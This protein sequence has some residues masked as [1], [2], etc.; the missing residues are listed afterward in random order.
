MLIIVIRLVAT[1]VLVA[2]VG[3]TRIVSSLSHLHYDLRLH[4]GLWS[5]IAAKVG[6]SFH[7]RLLLQLLLDILQR[8][9]NVSL[10]G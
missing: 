2:V 4:L 8:S 6:L 7:L 3:K 1:P 5:A 10:A 9:E